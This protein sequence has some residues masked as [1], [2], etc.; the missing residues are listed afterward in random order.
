M[1]ARESHEDPRRSLRKLTLFINISLSKKPTDRDQLKSKG[2]I[3]Y[4]N[5]IIKVILGLIEKHIENRTAT[6]SSRNIF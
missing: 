2:N 1:S 5:N 4:N 6:F 3:G